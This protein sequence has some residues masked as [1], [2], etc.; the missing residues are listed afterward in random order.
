MPWW[1]AY[2]AGVALALGYAGG[3]LPPILLAVALPGA[4][5]LSKLRRRPIFAPWI[6]A[7]VP[8]AVGFWMLGGGKGNPALSLVLGVVGFIIFAL[9]AKGEP[10]ALPLAFLG[11]AVVLVAYFS[12][13]QGSSG[14][15]LRWLVAH[16][17]SD[18]HAHQ[19]TLAF[20][21]T[22]HF[23]FYGLTGLTALCA[24]RAAEAESPEA[25]RTALLAAFTLAAFD[26][27]RQSG[28]ANRT[29][30]AWDMLLDLAG[31]AAFVGLSVWRARK[32]R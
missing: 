30:S 9:K 5:A 16:G 12:G 1:I 20:R 11:G 17:M 10:V 15:M 32:K 18:S 14:T 21:K 28:Y 26:E 7:V 8:T 29:G 3:S 13:G 4:L 27:F 6:V 19:V 23:T 25:V 2:A 24:A 31:A 22:V